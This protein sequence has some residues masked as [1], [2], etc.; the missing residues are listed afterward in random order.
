[1]NFSTSR[2]IW[3]LLNFSQRRSVLVLLVMML[4]AMFLEAVS[5]GMVIPAMTMLTQEDG[6]ANNMVFQKALIALGNP[7]Q[8]T[9][10]IA[11]MLTLVGVYFVKTI[12]LAFMAWW[13]TRFAF[14]IQASLSLRL[15]EIYLRQSYTFH[16]QKNSAQLIRN[17]TNEVSMFTNSVSSV[18]IVAS[19]L[20]VLVGLLALVLYIEPVGAISAA[21][22]L[23]L[24]SWIFHWLTASYIG[25]WGEAR[26]FH[27]GMRYQHLQQGLSGV[28]DVLLLGREAGFIENF[29]VHNAQVAH[30]GHLQQTIERIPRLW[31]E[32]VA[33]IGLAIVVISM[34]M[35]HK[36][37]GAV[38]TTL[39][40]F[41][42]TSFRLLPSVSRIFNGIQAIRFGLPA[43]NVLHAELQNVIPITKADEQSDHLFRNVLEIDQVS[44]CYQGADNLAVRNVSL[45]ISKGESIGFVGKSGSGKSTLADICLGLIDPNAGEVRVDGKDIRFNLRAWQNQIGYVPQ[46]IYLTDDTLRRNVAFGLLD[47]QIDNAAVLRAIDGAK[48][49]EFL[50]DL[51][52]GLETKV[53]ERGVRLSGG[54]R[55]RIG[56]ARALYHN[57]SVLMLDEATSA[58]DT[59]TEIEVM[60]TVNALRGEKTIV[61][62]AHRLSTVEHCDKIF[63]FKDGGLVGQVL[64]SDLISRNLRSKKKQQ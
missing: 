58:L 47:D 48:L 14:G 17:V 18:V 42:A 63:E 49:S 22:V 19:E 25:N 36:S 3:Q 62:I 27:E 24:A 53:G 20:L 5:I 23:G 50:K 39:G 26:Q 34:L 52:D 57:P 12:F 4:I 9:L 51:P 60:Q 10:I 1:M 38:L 21:C 44:F 54:Q 35:Q 64:H 6:A 56:I 59:A 28:K 37:T 15:F 8:Q 61:I 43:I 30:A 33:V 41:A 29:R 32:F 55:Q 2:K 45:S 7:S 16:L 31:L 11:G 46:S 40:L 13:Q